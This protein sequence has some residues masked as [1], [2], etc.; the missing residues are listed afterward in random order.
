MM[1]R[2]RAVSSLLPLHQSNPAQI[3]RRCV[4]LLH[5]MLTKQP[6]IHQLEMIRKK[7]IPSGDQLY[8]RLHDTEENYLGIMTLPQALQ[9]IEPLSY[10]SQ[11]KR[12]VYQIK[13][14]RNPNSTE[15]FATEWEKGG[16]HNKSFNRAGRSKDMPLRTVVTPDRLW[17]VLSAA[18]ED[19]IRGARVEFRLRRRSQRSHP[20]DRT[21]TVDWA[22]TN[23][24]HLRPDTIMA[25]MPAGTTMLAQP[26]YVHGGQ[27]ILMWAME[28]P[29]ALKR[30][31]ASTPAWVKQMG[32]WDNHLELK[33]VLETK[34]GHL[35]C[36]S[37]RQIRKVKAARKSGGGQNQ[38]HG[39]S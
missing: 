33:G 13:P 32:A 37:Q 39:I 2:L 16:R 34:Y 14:L 20:A 17:Q 8:L 35:K 23:A 11:R 4:H 22:L 25:A 15:L 28:Y 3:R 6:L 1:T 30:A 29:P 10:L 5:Q 27:D 18:Y 26:C 7:E 31:C 12:G 21:K 24:L 9:R 19:L 36:N 38:K